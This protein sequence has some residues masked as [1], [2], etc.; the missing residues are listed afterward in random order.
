MTPSSLP[1]VVAR[2][3]FTVS[4]PAALSAAA[5]ACAVG[6]PPVDH[7][8]RRGPRARGA[9]PSTNSEPRPRSMPSDSQTTSMSGVAASK[10][11]IV[12]SASVR[13]TACGLGLSWLQPHARGGRRSAAK[14]RGA[15]SRQ[16]HERDAAVVGLGAGDDVVGG[17]QPRVP[18]GGG[19]PAVVDQQRER[20]R[21]ARGG[22]RRI[23][24]R[25][26][27]GEDDQRGE[28]RAAAASATTACAPASLPSA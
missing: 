24:Q 8:E 6:R 20:R 14:C 7:G 13:S 28:Q 23:P 25:S 2:S 11:A 22:D 16:R 4:A 12:G 26:G 27:G 18:A 17:A 15:A 19:G 10:R 1:P 21:A 3:T 9:S 5:S